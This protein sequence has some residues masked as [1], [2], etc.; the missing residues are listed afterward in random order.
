MATKKN[1]VPERR[2]PTTSS[3][4]S[5]FKPEEKRPTEFWC[6]RCAKYFTKQQN[7]F[8]TSKSEIYLANNGYLPVCKSC[9]SELYLYY[10]EKT[11]DELEACRR[12]CMK[13]DI[14]Y[15]RELMANVLATTNK[16]VAMTTYIGRIAAS[17]RRT[18]SYDDT[19]E[20]EIIERKNKG[21]LSDEELEDKNAKIIEKGRKDW[22]LD[23]TADDFIFLDKE[24][25]DWDNR[26]G[27]DGKTR[28]S[29]VREMCVIKL[30]QNKALVANDLD[31][32]NKFSTQFQKTLTTAELTPKQ[33]SEAEKATEKPLGVMIEMFENERPIPEPN[34]EWRDVDGI[35]K[36]IMVFFIGHLCAML[37]LKNKYAKMY[38]EEMDRLSVSVPEEIQ[39]GDSE[40]IFDYLLENGFASASSQDNDS[41]GG[42][43]YGE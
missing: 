42:G 36:L 28:E 14:Y 26:C 20:E 40:D 16:D 12:V 5:G 33:V 9:L 17:G 24:Y 35:M 30:M 31:T 3:T 21:L 32:Y 15:S 27:I 19:I 4:K 41:P 25:E 39:D 37:G 43:T 22:G 23:L 10:C 11:K 7:N 6:V 38:K 2:V 1:S 29:L 34:P 8:P 13:F 18:K